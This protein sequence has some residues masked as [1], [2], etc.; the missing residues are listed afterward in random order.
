MS[1]PIRYL[2]FFSKL[3]TIHV[4][5]GSPYERIQRLLSAGEN[6]FFVIGLSPRRSRSY[7]P[8]ACTVVHHR[9]LVKVLRRLG[10]CGRTNLLTGHEFHVHV[11]LGAVNA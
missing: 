1:K 7:V 2:V 3:H 6:N 9:T 5:I 4:L 11:R 8:S 10:A